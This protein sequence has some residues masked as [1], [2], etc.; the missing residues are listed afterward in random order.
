M[1]PNHQPAWFSHRFLP[2]GSLDSWLVGI[3][4]MNC[5]TS[6]YFG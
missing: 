1:V 4:M 6:Q 3:S 5:D 2:I